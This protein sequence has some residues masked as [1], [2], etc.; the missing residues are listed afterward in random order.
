MQLRILNR[1]HFLFTG[2]YYLCDGRFPKLKHLI[3]PF[4]WS[5]VGSDR[6][7]WSSHLES[8]RKDIERTF[9]SIKQRFGC[10]V[11][12]IP[13]QEDRRLEQ[14]INACCVLHNIIFDYNGADNW[15]DQVSHGVR[16]CNVEAEDDIPVIEK[17]FSYIRARHQ[18]K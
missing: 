9:G 15:K 1:F 3:C 6:Q 7:N 13:I 4:K 5:S 2:Y 10:L 18:N 17:V 16:S 8:T 11:N 12:P 14:L